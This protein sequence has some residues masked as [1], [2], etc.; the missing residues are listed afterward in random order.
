VKKEDEEAE[1]GVEFRSYT[2]GVWGSEGKSGS[3]TS[4]ARIF[5]GEKRSK[6]VK[7]KELACLNSLWPSSGVEGEG[8]GCESISAL[9][10]MGRK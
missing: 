9:I 3:L 6:T 10:S 8:G 7:E 4:F 1:G 2:G 5:G